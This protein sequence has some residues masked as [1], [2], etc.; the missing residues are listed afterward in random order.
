[1]KRA[2]TLDKRG[3]RRMLVTTIGRIE[4]LQDWL[5]WDTDE[6]VRAECEAALVQQKAKLAHYNEL[7]RAALAAEATALDA[8]G[9]TIPSWP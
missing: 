2:R 8:P 6:K 1:M 3:I 7:A 4:R 5:S 9:S